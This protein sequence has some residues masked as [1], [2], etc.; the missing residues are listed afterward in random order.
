MPQKYVWTHY[1]EIK[2]R[3]YHLS[4]QRILRI[5][6][7]PSR[8]EQGIVEGAVACMQSGGGLGIF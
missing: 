8:V 6:K 4:A 2:L 7:Y 3:A 5:I 1:A